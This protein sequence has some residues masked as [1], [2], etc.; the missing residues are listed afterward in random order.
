MSNSHDDLAFSSIHELAPKIKDGTVSPVTL[1]EIALERI[2]NLNNSLKCL[3]RRL[4]RRS[5]RRG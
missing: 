4:A 3:P 5:H 2:T 1:T